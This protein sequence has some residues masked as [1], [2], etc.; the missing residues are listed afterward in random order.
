[1]AYEI[2][3]GVILIYRTDQNNQSRLEVLSPLTSSWSLV[4]IDTVRRSR[5]L[6]PCISDLVYFFRHTF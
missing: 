2:L 5:L 4:S 1:M 3:L 6:S